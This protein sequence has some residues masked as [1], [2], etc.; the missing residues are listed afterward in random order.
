[1]PVRQQAI[2]LLRDL[3]KLVI[4]PLVGH[5]DGVVDDSTEFWIKRGYLGELLIGV[6]VVNSG[7]LLAGIKSAS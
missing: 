5:R 4:Q 3:V 7:G 2:Y 1:V 6:H